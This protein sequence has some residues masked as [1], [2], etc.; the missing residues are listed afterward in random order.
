MQ[1]Q[2]INNL[3]IKSCRQMRLKIYAAEQCNYKEGKKSEVIRNSV[4]TVDSVI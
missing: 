3:Q 2:I 1:E 4:N